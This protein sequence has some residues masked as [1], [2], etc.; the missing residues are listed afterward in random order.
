MSGWAAAVSWQAAQ[1]ADLGLHVAQGAAQVALAQGLDH[2][3]GQQSLAGIHEQVE[4]RGIG[5]LAITAGKGLLALGVAAEGQLPPARIVSAPV[6]IGPRRRLQPQGLGI[7]LGLLQQPPRSLDVRHLVQVISPQ[8]PD[9]APQLA[10]LGMKSDPGRLAD[11]MGHP[12]NAVI[13]LGG[14]TAS[15]VSS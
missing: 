8:L 6:P 11:L 12:M 14:C 3:V 10:A 5:G 1:A 9:L 13:S 2:A 4:L 7:A 15:F